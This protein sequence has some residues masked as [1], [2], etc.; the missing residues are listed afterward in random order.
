MKLSSY[1]KI[2]NIGHPSVASLFEGD[3]TIEEKIDGSQFSFGMIN[4]ELSLKSKGSELIVDAPEK[5]FTK[6]IQQIVSISHLLHPGWVY[7]GEYLQKPKHNTLAYDRIPTNHVMI[8]DIMIS[9]ENYISYQDKQ[10]EA[11][12][13]GF[14]T[15]PLIFEGNGS[16]YNVTKLVSLMD[17]T[18]VLGGAKIEGFVVKNYR[19]F[20]PDGKPMMGKYVSENF[21]E[22]NNV[23][24]KKENPTNKD[25]LG[26]LCEE[27][28]NKARWQKSIIHL[29]EKG[30]LTN[31]PKDIGILLKEI[32]VDIESE[33]KQEII[34][35]LWNWAKPHIMRGAIRGFPEYYKEHLLEKQFE[36]KEE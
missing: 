34:E 7:R 22:V 12:R 2:F 11:I 15:V 18:S 8:Y 23:E 1:P 9:D 21:K 20:T 32:Q 29:D 30:L 26:L 31:S 17:R 35:K 36:K 13:L 3:I 25:V 5:M 4:G 16:E 24:W 27:F 28:R 10:V 6:A 33:A 14:E 19:Q